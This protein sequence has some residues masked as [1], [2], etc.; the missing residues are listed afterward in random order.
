MWA[1]VGPGRDKA[2][3]CDPGRNL[4]ALWESMDFSF[5]QKLYLTTSGV[6][7][8]VSGGETGT[9]PLLNSV[10]RPTSLCLPYLSHQGHGSFQGVNFSIKKCFSNMLN[11]SLA[12]Y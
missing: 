11:D 9:T 2:A 4:I 6:K 12:N 5:Q 7:V 3:H 10:L 1:Q 8:M